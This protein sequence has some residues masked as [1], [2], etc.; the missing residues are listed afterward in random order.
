MRHKD[1][2]CGSARASRQVMVTERTDRAPA[3]AE[4]LVTV[5]GPEHGALLRSSTA[6]PHHGERKV[7]IRNWAVDCLLSLGIFTCFLLATSFLF[8]RIVRVNRV[9]LKLLVE[10]GEVDLTLLNTTISYTRAQT[11]FKECQ[12]VDMC[13]F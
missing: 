13:E 10:M 12:A 5:S 2:G 6:P 11:I 1:L 3:D 9:A 8:W 4:P 7:R